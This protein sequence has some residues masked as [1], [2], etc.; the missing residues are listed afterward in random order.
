MTSVVYGTGGS[1]ILEEKSW[2]NTPL[3]AADSMKDVPAVFAPWGRRSL[4]FI[5]GFDIRWASQLPET[6]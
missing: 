5:G 3:C 6:N 1:Y 4:Q 2:S